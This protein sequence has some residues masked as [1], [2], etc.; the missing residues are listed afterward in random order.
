MK[1]AEINAIYA[2]KAA[3]FLAAGYTINTNT[4]N[5]SQGEIA[6]IDFRKGNEVIRLLLT[7][8]TIWGETFRTSDAIIL[9]VGRS[10][11]ERVINTKGFG[12]D[13]IIWNDRLEVIKKRIFY[14]I[15]GRRDSDWY[16]EGKE[17]EK[18]M[19]LYYNRFHVRCEM[20]R[21]EEAL[22]RSKDITTDEIKRI[23]LPAV[24]RHL[25]KPA[26]KAA[27]IDKIV[28]RWNEDHFEYTVTT[29]G[30]KTVVLH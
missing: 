21:I 13:A 14:R 3:E 11:D 26:L 17:G 12:R 8:E 2:A 22:T 5:G 18:A 16:L 30:K 9:T 28:R 10:T 15:G 6:K 19:D 4:M 23:V 27:R 29:L 1:S 24:R 20:E 7:S 25:N